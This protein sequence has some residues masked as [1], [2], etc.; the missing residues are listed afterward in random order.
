MGKLDYKPR[1]FK[2]SYCCPRKC[3]GC[4]Y[5]DTKEKMI[6]HVKDEH[7]EHVSKDSPVWIKWQVS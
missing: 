2:V 4:Q 5:I 6:K 3:D 1:S 7:G